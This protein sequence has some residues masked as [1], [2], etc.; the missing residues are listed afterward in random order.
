MSDRE[1]QVK[2]DGYLSEPFQ[3]TSGVP[4]GSHLGPLLFSLFINDLGGML[5]S[6][7]LLFADDMK[8]Y[9]RVTSP[10]DM[11]LLQRD[12]NCVFVF[13]WC[14]INEMS[15]NVDKCCFI[16]FSRTKSTF[17]F[18]YTI[19]SVSLKE[20]FVIKDL[21]VFLDTKLTFS[22]HFE[23]VI[24][25]ANKMLG[26]V[27]RSCKDFKNVLAVKSLYVSF[28][29]SVLEYSCIVWAPYYQIHINRL[30]NVHHKFI[31]FASFI[32]SRMG[33]ILSYDQTIS[34]L[35]LSALSLRREYYDICFAF[36]VLNNFIK[37]PECLEAFSIHVPNRQTRAQKLLHV[38]Y[39]RAY[40][41]LY[42]P[43]NRIAANVNKFCNSV[44]FFNVSLNKFKSCAKRAVLG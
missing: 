21:G 38:P 36:K 42:S 5:S 18:Q 4:Q 13:S 6:N 27:K 40:Y 19:N 29:R 12:I 9:K 39:C 33:I 15:L 31:K 34:Y 11:I 2:V 41:L 37:S 7:Y 14:Q 44:D 20:V 32:L 23:K 10:H 25:K 1:Q 22:E 8:L 24:C 30:E 3:A 43:A 17:P 26:F 35:G 16:R 28:V